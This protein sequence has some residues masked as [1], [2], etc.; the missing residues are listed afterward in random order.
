[1][2]GIK[3]CGFTEVDDL[4]AAL[5]LE[6]DAFGVVL[7]PCPQQASSAQVSRLLQVP[8]GRAIAVA[9]TG[10][11]TPDAVRATLALG[12]DWV[13]AVMTA[14]DWS[15]LG[16][17]ACAFPVLFDG[18]DLEHEA[19]A[20][21]R[22]GALGRRCPLG[23]LNV[24]GAAGGGNGVAPDHQRVAQVARS[25]RLMLS[26]GLRAENVEAAIARVRPTS[27]D[28]SSFTEHSPGRKDVVRMTA[29]VQAVRAATSTRC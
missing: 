10:R 17:A 7:D 3:I 19:E 27:V 6:I 24:D 13:Q 12:F 15:A 16:P 14:A 22:A 20:L 11:T 4:E 21:R 8:R 26:G 29:F 5:D 23:E 1:M 25:T 18:P 28:V 9:V 2:V